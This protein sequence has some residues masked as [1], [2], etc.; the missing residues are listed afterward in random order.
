MVALRWS[1]V[2]MI[3]MICDILLDR[4]DCF[5][6]IEGNR[7]L[8]KSTLAWH[9]AYG[10]RREMKR[11]G[12]DGYK[13]I[14]KRDLLYKRDEVIHFFKARKK[15][16]IG[17]EMINVSFNRDFYE[18]DQKDLIKIINMNR[19][20]NNFFEACVPQFQTLDSQIK[21]LCKIRISVIRRG[22]AIIQ[23]PNRSIYGRD[24]W[25]QQVNEKIERKWMENKVKNPKYTQLTT[26][27][28]FLRFP[29]LTEKQEERYQTIKDEKRNNLFKNLRQEEM[30]ETDPF[31]LCY[32]RL[33]K[34][35]IKDRA[36]VEGFAYAMGMNPSSLMYKLS[37]RLKKDEIDPIVK[38]YYYTKKNKAHSQSLATS[39]EEMEM[40]S[41]INT[42]KSPLK[43]RVILGNSY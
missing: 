37:R 18:E 41:I 25:D 2:R 14:A 27:R 43:D 6:V 38:N 5:L 26:F 33:V 4:F 21:N 36:M 42:V 28:G 30:E 15:T 32:K 1:M 35:G 40:R 29:A 9:L 20:H 34:G 23:T 31:E 3:G 19:D 39:Q 11:R 13:F 8:G 7:G 12:V 10:V 16:G 22:L 24:K 17:D